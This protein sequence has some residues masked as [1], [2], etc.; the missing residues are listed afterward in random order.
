MDI[1]Q[2]PGRAS[3]LAAGPLEI[4]ATFLQVGIG[5]VAKR[6]RALAFDFGLGTVL[7]ADGLL[8]PVAIRV[9]ERNHPVVSGQAL[10]A[11]GTLGCAACRVMRSE[12]F[13]VDPLGLICPAAVVLDNPIDYLGHDNPPPDPLFSRLGGHGPF[14]RNVPP[15]SCLRNAKFGLCHPDGENR[16]SSQPVANRAPTFSSRACGFSPH[17]HPLLGPLESRFIRVTTDAAEPSGTAMVPS[18]GDSRAPRDRV[19]R[20]VAPLDCAAVRRAALA[21]RLAKR[22]LLSMEHEGIDEAFVYQGRRAERLDGGWG[23]PN[24]YP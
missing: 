5:F 13:R 17:R 19:P 16:R 20:Y 21:S 2:L 1:N 6:L 3:P 15:R 18:S 22:H 8:M 4:V 11:R 7:A 12:G 14:R 24:A 10:L 9:L 23:P